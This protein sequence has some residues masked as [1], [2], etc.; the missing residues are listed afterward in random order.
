[1]WRAYRLHQAALLAARDQVIDQ[2]AEPPVRGRVEL[3]DPVGEVVHTV[4]WFHDHAVHPQ[5][6]APDPFYELRVVLA[7]HPDPAGPG[8]PG[9]RPRHPD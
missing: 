3:R 6:M 2:H 5:I 8:D 4:E 1:V 9:P 7:L